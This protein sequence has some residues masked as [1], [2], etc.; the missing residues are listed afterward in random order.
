MRRRQVLALGAGLAALATGCGTAT[1]GRRLTSASLSLVVPG[2]YGSDLD[3]V[4]RA[5]AGVAERDGLVRAMRVA[6]HPA[7]AVLGEFA[8][9]GPP[10]RMMIAEPGLVG[11]VRASRQAAAFAGTTP[12]ARLCG[13]WEVLVVPAASPF[14]SFGEFAVAIRRDPDKMALAG[15]AE[16]GVDHVL[17]GMLAQCLGLDARLLRYLAYPTGDEAVTAL[18]GGHVAAVLAG[19]NGVRDLLRAGSLRAL[20]VSS[21]DRI[22]GVDAPTLLECDVHLYCAN[23]RGLLGP[24]GLPEADRAALTGLCHD[25]AGSARWARICARNGW[26]PLYLDGDDFRQWL[27]VEAA[28]LSRT[29]GDLGLRV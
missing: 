7:H 5:V 8:R 22:D 17:F 25:L 28:R 19:H 3:D 1:E 18:A 16:G 21:P 12:L 23:W 24:A 27:R 20:A 29:L 9:A 11:T 14:R 26:T 10:G 13:E 15:R 4:A 6:D 2:P